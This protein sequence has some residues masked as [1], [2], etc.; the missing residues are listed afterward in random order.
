MLNRRREAA[1]TLNTYLEARF[2]K[3][4]E[5]WKSLSV[6]SR[7]LKLL[8]QL[9]SEGHLIHERSL[10]QL[11]TSYARHNAEGV[12][13]L[14]SAND[15][16]SR[17]LLSDVPVSMLGA[18]TFSPDASKSLFAIKHSCAVQPTAADAIERTLRRIFP[19]QSWVLS[20]LTY[21]LVYRFVAQPSVDGL[22]QFLA[23]LFPLPS[24]D[25]QRAAILHLLHD[26]A[27]GRSNL[28]FQVYIAMMA[29]PYDACQLLLSHIERDIAQGRPPGVCRTDFL[30]LAADEFGSRRAADLLAVIDG[31]TR[32]SEQILHHALAARFDLSAQNAEKIAGILSTDPSA[33][34][35]AEDSPVAILQRMRGARY[36]VKVDFTRVTAMQ[37]NWS[38]TD[39]GRL[40]MAILRSM[41][42]VDRTDPSIERTAFLLLAASARHVSHYILAGPSAMSA[43]RALV[44]AGCR[45]ED[46]VDRMEDQA[47]ETIRGLEG[48]GDRSWILILQ[49]KLRQLQEQARIGSWIRT[50]RAEAEYETSFLSGT[51]WTFADEVIEA[52]LLD[53]FLT[54]DGAYALLLMESERS[55]DATRL[56][57]VMEILLEGLDVSGAVERLIAEYGELA[58]IFVRRFLTPANL[59]F[60][61]M[62]HDHLSALDERVKALEQCLRK[63]GFGKLSEEA[64]RSETKTLTSELLLAN[65]NT[66]KFEIPWASFRRDSHDRFEDLHEVYVSLMGALKENKALSELAYSPAQ[67]PNG[68]KE[69]Y[70]VKAVDTPLFQIVIG[71][72]ADFFEH[73]AFGLEVIL[74][75]RFRHKNLP[76]EL[77]AALP[78]SRRVRFRNVPS[79]VQDEIVSAYRPI[80]EKT[81]DQWADAR[82]QTI[83][84]D[85][86]NG[87]F[88]LVPTQSQLDGMLTAADAA[89][90]L[91]E[92]IGVVV[93][94]LREQLSDA[95]RRDGTRIHLP[96]VGALLGKLVDG[97]NAIPVKKAARLLGATETEIATARDGEILGS[98]LALRHGR[99][100]V[101]L[102][103][104]EIDALSSIRLQRIGARR[105]GR[106]IGIPTYAV[107]GIV[108]S[109]H[110]HAHRHPWLTTRYGGPVV[111]TAAVDELTR[112]I[113][114]TSTKALQNP[115]GLQ[116][117]M[118]GFG[119]G[120]KP[121]VDVIGAILE[122]RI[123]YKAMKDD[124]GKLRIMVS[125][126]TG[127]RIR[128]LRPGY[129]ADSYSQEDALEIL[130]LN[131]K[132]AA[133][134]DPMRITKG[135]LS[136]RYNGALIEQAASTRVSLGELMRRT[137]LQP[138]TIQTKL[139]SAGMTMADELGWDRATIAALLR[140][141]SQRS[142]S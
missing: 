58:P 121:W 18:R 44:S 94:W 113:L 63:T 95:I 86:P 29:H 45:F 82:L 124:D 61:R 56:D 14:E 98:A 84:K 117:V 119:G 125:A 20:H 55:I 123:R 114:S 139:E 90:S 39:G 137:A 21:P 75:G 131:V 19:K 31:T 83:R 81:L 122:G 2:F 34:D 33:S 66:G 111:T 26:E 53:D 50:I 60:N 96:A 77:W 65:L 46:G 64:Y 3:L 141:L 8:G 79:S 72:I 35:P 138:K 43:A 15:E 7:D 91:D 49:W 129:G 80:L 24:Q 27:I 5:G 116:A 42:M 74:S 9:R 4:P 130:N 52:N 118:R 67:F 120:P 135:S 110:L 89:T 69:D 128:E 32:A 11:V 59:R 93:D 101:H 40:L 1:P 22:D 51:D 107:H 142:L 38:F 85:T 62:A 37:N 106:M 30:K 70:R 48:R 6:T 54:F 47:G 132:S 87:L 88:D 115:L 99:L 92:I 103:T 16:A 78:G 28:G 36:P 133:T 57:T 127:D 108:A 10:F 71:L 102:V 134:I 100:S 126:A 76:Q 13:E 112:Q 73:N 41:Y 17:L 68:R 23:Y 140:S 109:G 105:A 136:G 12:R 25:T 104:S 97:T